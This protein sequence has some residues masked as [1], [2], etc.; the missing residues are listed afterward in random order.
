MKTFN[1]LISPIEPEIIS[2]KLK[3]SAYYST[4]K[5]EDPIGNIIGKTKTALTVICR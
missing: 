1:K 3:I 2:I 5:I 4:T